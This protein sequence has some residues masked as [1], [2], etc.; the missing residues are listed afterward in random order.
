MFISQATTF[1]NLTAAIVKLEFIY[2][3]SIKLHFFF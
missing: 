1:K 2:L 3:T